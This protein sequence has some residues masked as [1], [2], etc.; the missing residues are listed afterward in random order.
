MADEKPK[1][2]MPVGK[3][4]KKGQS[5]NLDGRPKVNQE[6]RLKAR[7][8]VDAHVIDAWI[9]EVTTRGEHWIE[10]SKLLA[11][12]GYGKPTEHIE[13]NGSSRPLE[14]ATDEQL[15]AAVVKGSK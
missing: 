15:L 1:R 11:A 13:L 9:S 7:C 12:Y 14:T 2:K 8:A 3:P 5:G 4:F 6:F 10:A